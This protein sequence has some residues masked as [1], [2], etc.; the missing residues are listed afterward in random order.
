M[1]I[2]YAIANVSPHIIAEA[3]QARGLSGSVSQGLRFGKWG[4][5][6]TSFVEVTTDSKLNADIVVMRLL[7]DHGEEC[8]YRTIDNAEP[9]LL[10]WDGCVEDV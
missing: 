10:Y 8:A 2:R 3:V 6:P 1:I 7:Q 5:E 4:I 9:E